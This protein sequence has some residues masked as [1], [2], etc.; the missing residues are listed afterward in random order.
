MMMSVG[1]SI[2]SE[3][4]MHFISFSSKYNMDN[5]WMY[6][7]TDAYQLLMTHLSIIDGLINQWISFIDRFINI[8]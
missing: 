6:R 7:S 8:L 1:Q 2:G 5:R 4:T 3:V